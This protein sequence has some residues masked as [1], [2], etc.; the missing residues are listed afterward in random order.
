MIT[1]A[2]QDF[3]SNLSHKLPV[4]PNLFGNLA[5]KGEL[6]KLLER[7]PDKFGMTILCH[8]NDGFYL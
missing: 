7:I 4:I 3:F 2:R 5:F 1:N 8:L 6:E